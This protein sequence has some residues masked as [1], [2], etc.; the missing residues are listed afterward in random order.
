M[1]DFL[2]VAAQWLEFGRPGEDDEPMCVHHRAACAMGAQPLPELYVMAIEGKRRAGM[3]VPPLD[4]HR[5]MTRAER[6]RDAEEY[7]ALLAEV[8]ARNAAIEAGLNA[9]VPPWT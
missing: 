4:E 8:K 2:N 9:G 1:G 6:A 7:A 3:P 5:P